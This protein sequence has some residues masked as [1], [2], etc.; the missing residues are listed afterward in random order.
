MNPQIDEPKKLPS[1]K[2]YTV[3]PGLGKD[4]LKAQRM[5]KDPNEVS[6]GLIA[7]LATVEGKPLV[8]ED[9]HEM[10]LPDVL[11]LVAEVMPEEKK[12]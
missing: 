1:G 12:A 10:P 5:T 8:I 3:R 2:S 4:L 11:H 7:V 9:V 6:F